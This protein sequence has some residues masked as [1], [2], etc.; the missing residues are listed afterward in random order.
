MDEPIEGARADSRMRGRRCARLLFWLVRARAHWN[1]D[2]PLSRAVSSLPS[3]TV[4]SIEDF[5]RDSL[6]NR[7]APYGTVSVQMVS[8]SPVAGI[9]IGTFHTLFPDYAFLLRQRASGDNAQSWY[10]HQLAELGVVGSLGWIVWGL[11]FGWLLVRGR[12]RRGATAEASLVRGALAAVALVSAVS[13]PTQQF[14]NSFTVIVFVFWYFLLVDDGSLDVSPRG[15]AVRSAGRAA[16]C[17]LV[18]LH[19]AASVYVGWTTFRPPLRA[20]KGRLGL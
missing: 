4:A 14:A 9:G 16:V 7:G 17:V 11:S 12:A 18:L 15:S 3:P 10:R 2:S 8:Q 6:W 13:M 1:T 20:L 19:V 5:A